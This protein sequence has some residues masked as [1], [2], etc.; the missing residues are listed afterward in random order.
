M[1]E[2]MVDERGVPVIELMVAGRKWSGLIDTG[3]NGYLELPEELYDARLARQ[4]PT[5]SASRS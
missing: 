1:I 4:E 5:R 2:G 3:F